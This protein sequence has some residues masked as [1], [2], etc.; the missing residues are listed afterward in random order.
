MTFSFILNLRQ[1]SSFSKPC[2]F[3]L[4]FLVNIRGDSH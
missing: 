3:R 2:C 4:M 1:L